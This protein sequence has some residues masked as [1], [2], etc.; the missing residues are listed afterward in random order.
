MSEE[1][2]GLPIMSFE[3]RDGLEEWLEEQTQPQT[4]GDH[5]GI[6]LKLAKKE[7]GV[8]SVSRQEAVDAGLCFGWIDGLINSFDGQ[9][10]LLRFTPRRKKSKWSLINVERAEALIAE[11]RV[12]PPGMREIEAAKA[13]GRWD[14]AYP[15]SSR[16]E[17][18]AD[19]QEALEARPEAAAFFATLNGA[20][21]YAIL[22]RLHDVRDPAKREAAIG[23][24]VEK[25]ERGETVYAAGPIKSQRLP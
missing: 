1:R 7:S 19:L 11:G 4:A 13:D 5:N 23:K 3:S 14:A 10:Y 2:G 12:R 8:V 17:V 9:F 21:R 24:W 15:P 6:W 22:Y 25:L 16:I 20:N 18:P